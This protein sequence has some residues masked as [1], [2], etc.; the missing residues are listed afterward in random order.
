MKNIT[1]TMPEAIKDRILIGI[2]TKGTATN[3]VTFSQYK[4]IQKSV[5]ATTLAGKATMTEAWQ[6]VRSVEIS[7]D[8][9]RMP[10][11][12]RELLPAMKKESEK[13]CW[14][15]VYCYWK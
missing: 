4:S 9:E 8:D 2:R 14:D 15:T 10:E 13:N 7:L 11:A 5:H 6:L 1:A 12:Q 3:E